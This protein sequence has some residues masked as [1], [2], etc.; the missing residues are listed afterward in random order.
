MR[1][2]PRCRCLAPGLTVSRISTDGGVK[3]LRLYG[4]P[5]S[6]YP[7]FS[8]LVPLPAPRAADSTGAA[9][10]NARVNGAAKPS[11]GRVPK[12]PAVPLNPSAFAPYGS[13]IQ[14]YP[15]ERAAPKEIK[16]KR[17][18]F[19]TARKFNHLAPVEFVAPPAGRFSTADGGPVPSGQVNFCVFRCA[20]QNSEQLSQDGRGKRQWNVEVLERHE[21]SSQAFVP[22][23]GAPAQDG[24]GEYLVLVAL[25]G[26]GASIL[27]PTPFLVKGDPSIDELADCALPGRRSTGLGN[28]PRLHGDAQAGDQL[29]PERVARASDLARRGRARLCVRRARDG[30]RRGGLRDQV[31]R[32]RGRGGRR[33]GVTGELRAGFFFFFFFSVRVGFSSRALGVRS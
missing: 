1:S 26:A 14:S 23:G 3:R 32:G 19:G 22:M 25:P 10:S 27:P 8:A 21:F 6:Q 5:Q 31:V 13:V 33:G 29:P 17:V 11:A 9:S 20:P 30:R 2:S 16:I 24:E 15:D 7:D 12:I 4:R 18:N 28:T